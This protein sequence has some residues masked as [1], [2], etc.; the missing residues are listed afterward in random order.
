MTGTVTDVDAC[1][2]RLEVAVPRAEVAEETERAYRRLSGRVK[3]KG[4]RKGKVPRRVLERYYGEEVRAEVLNYVIS[5]S[6]R[7]I[8]EDRGMRPVGE[9]NVSDIRMEEDAPE[10]TFKATVEVVPPFELGQYAGLKVKVHRHAVTEEMVEEQIEALR[11]RAAAFEDVD[12]EARSGDY[13]LFDIEGFENGEAVPGTR[14]E[15]QALMI[16][17]DQSE[18]DLG[19]ALTGMRGG[20][21][22]EI[23]IDVPENAAP[24]IAGRRLTFRL[25]LKEVKE[26]HPPALDE[27][28]VKSLGRGYASAADLRADVAREM[29]SMEDANARRQG[30]S[31]LLGALLEAHPFEAP[32]TLVRGEA[33][34]QIREYERRLRQENP[35]V[36]LSEAKIEE[37]REE[38]RP[39]A[40]ERARRRILVERIREAEGIEAGAEEVQAQID[41]SAARYGMTPEKLRQ[42]MLTTGAMASLVSSINYNKTVEWLYERADVEFDVHDA[43]EH[44]EHGEG[45]RGPDEGAGEKPSPGGDSKE[46]G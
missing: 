45:S 41:L 43:A 14:G 7:R 34:E 36:R 40:E 44:G 5:A 39:E 29:E 19:D 18:K 11:R 22:K 24:G 9:P 23:E 17:S 42:R 20:E 2:K 32:P 30:I 10:L 21:E 28:F 26:A 16:G 35:D 8:L 4:F 3:I 13:V 12:R 6:Y 33:D 27:D 15:S 37:L 31:E 25:H 1:T 38:A 46:D